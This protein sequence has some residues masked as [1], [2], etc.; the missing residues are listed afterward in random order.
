MDLLLQLDY[1]HWLT[2]GVG[3]MVI[4]LLLV[5]SVFFLWMGVASLVVGV[6]LFLYPTMIWQLQLLS[7]SLLSVVLI[8]LAKKYWHTKSHDTTLNNR[9]NKLIG[10]IYSIASIENGQAKVRINDSLWLTRGCEHC[11]IG[12]QVKVVDVD[13]ITLVVEKYTQG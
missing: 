7:F 10:D 8:Y 6:V 4:E 2:L 3:L 9:A 13:S 5:G 11:K 1:W 12:Q